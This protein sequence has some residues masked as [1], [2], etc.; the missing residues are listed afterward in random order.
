[1]CL[2]IKLL[3]IDVLQLN[4]ETRKTVEEEYEKRKMI[5]YKP[6]S[7]Q[8]NEEKKGKN[9]RLRLRYLVREIIKKFKK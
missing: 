2:V 3:Q 1:M 5:L 9:T 7:S 4:K 6:E 8:N